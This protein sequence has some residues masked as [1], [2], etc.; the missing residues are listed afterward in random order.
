MAGKARKDRCGE[1]RWHGNGREAGHEATAKV[2]LP[3]GLGATAAG[4]PFLCA[5]LAVLAVA[6][7]AEGWWSGMAG[8]GGGGNG[9][10][11]DWR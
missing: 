1:P 5:G 9:T 2:Y 3:E 11:R 10:T 8:M 7:E 6:V 4:V